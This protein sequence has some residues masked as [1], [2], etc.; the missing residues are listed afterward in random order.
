M[1]LWR[2]FLGD[3][4]LLVWIHVAECQTTKWKRKNGNTI[5][6][7]EEEW[8]KEY[9]EEGEEKRRKGEKHF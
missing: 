4:T 1:T 5:R 8:E 3:V 7:K 6:K 2:C 9:E